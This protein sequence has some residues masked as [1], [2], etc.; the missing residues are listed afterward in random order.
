MTEKEIL[1]KQLCEQ[2]FAAVEVGLF[3]DTHPDCTHALEAM[4]NYTEK[5]N[6][7]KKKYEEKFGML[8][9]FSPNNSQTRWTWLDNGWPWENNAL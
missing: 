7:L 1:M 5:Y 9:I 3:L 6:E 4:K 8:D 2:Q